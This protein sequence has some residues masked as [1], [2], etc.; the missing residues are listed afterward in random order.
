M[1]GAV[2]NCVPC[3]NCKRDFKVDEGMWWEKLLVCP[4]CHKLATRIE[5]RGEARLRWMRANLKAGI[6]A[7][8]IAGK[9]QLATSEQLGEDQSERFLLQL[10]ELARRARAAKEQTDAGDDDRRGRPV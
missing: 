9:L 10:Q 6:K 4:D 1:E 2:S 7:T 8:L 3:M 5:E